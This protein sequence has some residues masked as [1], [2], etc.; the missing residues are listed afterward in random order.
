M[1]RLYAE[2]L[3]VVRVGCAVGDLDSSLSRQRLLARGAACAVWCLVVGCGR[4]RCRSDASAP[5]ALLA[6]AYLVVG[7]ACVLS[8]RGCV[9]CTLLV[10]QHSLLRANAAM[11]A[12]NAAMHAA[13]AA[14][15]AI[16]AL[17]C[18]AKQK[19]WGGKREGFN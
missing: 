5:E 10:V 13:N 18:F 9:C 2:A 16:A 1:A 6:R 12:A 7:S 19:A 17:F 3:P 11:H 15:H 8:V 4:V 14:M